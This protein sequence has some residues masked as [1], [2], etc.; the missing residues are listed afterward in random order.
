MEVLDCV[1]IG[2]GPAGLTAAIYLARFRRNIY[3]I[4]SGN[5]RA[6]LIPRS[7]N[8]PGF[9]KGVNG[10]ELLELL[11]AQALAC[12]VQVTAGEVVGLSKTSEL[13]EV[14]TRERC[15]YTRT[16]VLATGIKD[17]HPP[18][19]NWEANVCKAIIRLCPICDAY[20]SDAENIAVISTP[21]CALSHAQFLRTYFKNIDLYIHPFAALSE[22]DIQKASIANI[23]L[24]PC[25][26]ES[27]SV[28]NTKPIV[29]PVDGTQSE[30]D[31]LY[32]MQGEA[33]SLDLARKVGAEFSDAGKLI[34]DEHQCTRVN[35]LYAIGDVVSLLH[36]VSVATG[37]AAIAATHIHNSLPLNFMG[38]F[39]GDFVDGS[40]H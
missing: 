36:Q 23:Q 2:A 20:D 5:S 3:V 27:V 25:G 31:L 21:E 26:I 19:E 32:V 9:P 12:D 35:G 37:Q 29:K 6:Q 15:I 10:R 14:L 18:I 11:K 7:H 38:S 22:T 34:T 40:A 30:Y 16:V 24:K 13:F 39:A 17:M 8:Y 1:I 28:Q 33:R 4:D